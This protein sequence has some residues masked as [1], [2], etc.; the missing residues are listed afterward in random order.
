MTTP[1]L[2]LTNVSK[3]FTLHHQGMTLPV[4]HDVNFEVAAGELDGLTSLVTH[5]MKNVVELSVPLDVHI[6]VGSS[7]D[8]AGH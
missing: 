8:A 4:L 1:V 3:Q 7:W 5:E 2:R 6:G